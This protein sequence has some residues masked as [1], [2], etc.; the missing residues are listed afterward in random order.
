MTHE[1]PLTATMGEAWVIE[2]KHPREIIANQLSKQ[3]LLPG[4]RALSRTSN[5][6]TAAP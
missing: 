4:E 1:M 2:I 6:A 3:R 5:S